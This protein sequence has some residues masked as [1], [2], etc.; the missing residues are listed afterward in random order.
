MDWLLLSLILKNTAEGAEIHKFCSYWNAEVL[1]LQSPSA[2]DGPFWEGQEHF[3]LFN[4]DNFST[5]TCNLLPSPSS[6]G[7]IHSAQSEPAWKFYKADMPLVSVMPGSFIRTIIFPVSK[8]STLTSE[9]NVFWVLASTW[10]L[11]LS[12]VLASKLNRF[13]A[14]ML[15]SIV[16]V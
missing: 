12:S 11:P 10:K 6:Q 15:E 16:S 13:P 1:F 14:S 8:V 7:N 2:V 9:L 5:K 4:Q 3:A